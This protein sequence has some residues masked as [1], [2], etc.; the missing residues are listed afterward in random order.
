MIF[1]DYKYFNINKIRICKI[2]IGKNFILFAIFLVSLNLLAR[3][4]I[5]N[6]NNLTSKSGNLKCYLC[7][8][9]KC[10]NNIKSINKFLEGTLNKFPSDQASL[11]KNTSIDDINKL[12]PELLKSEFK[13]EM[14]KKELMI[15]ASKDDAEQITFSNLSANEYSMM[16]LHDENNN[17]ISDEVARFPTEA[18][19]LSNY[20]HLIALAPSIADFE[21]PPFEDMKVNLNDYS[22]KPFELELLRVIPSS[23]IEN[24]NEEKNKIMTSFLKNMDTVYHDTRVKS[25]D[26][27]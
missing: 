19:A 25:Y 23:K 1:E 16:C 9:E 6:I 22:S 15:Q 14:V 11:L 10:H 27:L 20:N 24:Q 5:I 21:I 18:F 7:P 2:K 26:C 17:H 12:T 13:F 8:N 3:D 4:L